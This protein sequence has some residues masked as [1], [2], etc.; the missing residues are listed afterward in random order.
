[1]SLAIRRSPMTDAHA[2]LG[3]RVERRAGWEVVADY[4]DVDVERTALRER[5]GIGDVTSRGKI[6]VRGD[7]D[8]VLR[9]ATG[10]VVARIADD[11]ALVVTGPG[12]EPDVM[13]AM[14]QAARGSA[15]LLTDVTHLYAGLALIGPAL[16]EVCARLSSWDPAGLRPG[17]ATGASFADVRAIVRRPDDGPAAL[18]LYVGAESAR[19]AW[20]TVAAVVAGQGGRPVGLTALLAEGW[21]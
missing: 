1:M 17:D 19:Y 9:G 16:P 5:V 13:P 12:G 20:E 14:E 4:G 21:S 7:V 6:D 3:A 18:E 11:W 10:G 8:A 15:A 2:K